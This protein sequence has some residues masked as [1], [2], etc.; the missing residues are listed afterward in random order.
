MATREVCHHVSTPW[1]TWVRLRRSG[2]GCVRD[3]AGG[4]R[5]DTRWPLKNGFTPVY[6]LPFS[7]I[8]LSAAAHAENS[9]FYLS[10][11]SS[12]CR[13]LISAD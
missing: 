5:R 12:V 9:R 10:A 3:G 2:A 11:I 6:P 8:A 1:L 13:L 4:R 7:Y